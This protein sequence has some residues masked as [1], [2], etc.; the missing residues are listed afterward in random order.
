MIEIVLPFCYKSCHK[1]VPIIYC[2]LGGSALSFQEKADPPSENWTQLDHGIGTFMALAI[3]SCLPTCFFDGAKTPDGPHLVEALTMKA[4]Q[5]Y[6]FFIFVSRS[7][8][9]LG[10]YYVFSVFGWPFKFPSLGFVAGLRNF[11]ANWLPFNLP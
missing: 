5:C 7:N 11:M 8:I 4:G 9:I 1:Y 3:S 2:P 10:F 6:N